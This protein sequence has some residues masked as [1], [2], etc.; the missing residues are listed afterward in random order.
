MALFFD[1]LL[2]GGG[3]GELSAAEFVG[4]MALREHAAGAEK[5]VEREP[6]ELDR[7]RR[8]IGWARALT[9]IIDV[10]ADVA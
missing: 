6:G 5:L 1:G 10:A 4:G 9:P 3:H 7:A 8:R 2:D